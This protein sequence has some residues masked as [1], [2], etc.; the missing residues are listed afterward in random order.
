MTAASV[1]AGVNLRAYEPPV[2]G[3]GRNV[4]QASTEATVELFFS[5]FYNAVLFIFDADKPRHSLR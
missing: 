1:R 4:T 3:E 5:M 2:A